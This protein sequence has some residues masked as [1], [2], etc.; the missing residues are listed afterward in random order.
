MT[1]RPYHPEPAIRQERRI[2]VPEQ[3]STRLFSGWGPRV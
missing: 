3:L 1:N 2:L